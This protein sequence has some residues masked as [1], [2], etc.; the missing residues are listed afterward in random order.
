MY[1][2]S[3]QRLTR[4][5]IGLAAV[6]AFA[7]A[8]MAAQAAPGD[9]TGTLGAGL[10]TNSI[11]T[12]TPFTAGLTGLAQNVYTEVGTMNVTDAT[13]SNAGYTIAVTALAPQVNGDP[14]LAGT[15]GSITLTPQTATRTAGNSAPTGPVASTGTSP[16]IVG[17]P[18]TIDTAT[19]N[20]GQGSWDTTADT[21]SMGV[22]STHAANNSLRVVIPADATAGAYTSTLT[23]TTAATVG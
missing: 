14:A 18:Y 16:S 15:G 23:F 1:K 22:G 17:A 5:A 21:G 10:L 19:S 4:T 9:V 12:I 3:T 11:P 8:P 2:F 6:S 7:L 13:G 20:T